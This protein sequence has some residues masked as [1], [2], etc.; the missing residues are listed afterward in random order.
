MA[1]EIE[2]KLAVAE[3][4]SLDEVRGICSFLSGG[5][6]RTT[7][8]MARYFDTEDGAL[9][10]ARL[11][12]RTRKEGWR[13]VAC[14]KGS[15]KSENGLHQRMEIERDVEHG[16]ADLT[17]FAD[18]EGAELVEPYLSAKL[19][20]IVETEFSRTSWLMGDRTAK[21]EIALDEG[22]VRAGG[23]TSPIRE[24]ELELKAGEV[25]ALHVLANWLKQ[26]FALTEENDSKYARGLALRRG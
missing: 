2:M 3:S 9:G 6:G 24:I 12:Y 5:E 20:P 23:K 25:E 15:G 10:K 19:V 13:W 16:D 21:I 22:E 7:K 1:Q 17:V 18:T 8:M 4:V 11:A 14:L 26:Q